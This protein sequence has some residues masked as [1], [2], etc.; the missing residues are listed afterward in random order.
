MYTQTCHQLKPDLST[1]A[2]NKHH[3]NR[4]ELL[5]FKPG[6]GNGVEL[7]HI[8]TLCTVKESIQYAHTHTLQSLYDTVAL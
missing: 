1:T 8:I 7:A 6:K 2:L 5:A 3:I 4:K